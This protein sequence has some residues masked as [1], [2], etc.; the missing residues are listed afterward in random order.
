MLRGGGLRDGP[1]SRDIIIF[2]SDDRISGA[3]FKVLLGK[4][5]L[6]DSTYILITYY[7]ILQM[8]N[9][10]ILSSSVSFHI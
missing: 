5:I 1:L 3:K 4:S 10:T 2:L 8:I 7:D 9:L 6:K